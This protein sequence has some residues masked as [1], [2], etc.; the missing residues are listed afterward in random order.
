MPNEFFAPIENAT[1]FITLFI[2]M[3]VM[4]NVIESVSTLAGQMISFAN[5]RLGHDASFIST[6]ASPIMNAADTAARPIGMGSK[7]SMKRMNRG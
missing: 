4:H 5:M 2:L 3:Q 6:V 1:L 7:N